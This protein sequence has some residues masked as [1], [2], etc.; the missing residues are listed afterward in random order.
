MVVIELAGKIYSMP[1]TMPWKRPIS[2][3][4]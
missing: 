3:P 2:L 1:T 4:I